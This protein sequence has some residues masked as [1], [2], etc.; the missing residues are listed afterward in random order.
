MQQQTAASTKNIKNKR[1]TKKP[2]QI[3]KNKVKAINLCHVNAVLF[4]YQSLIRSETILPFK[5]PFCLMCQAPTNGVPTFSFMFSDFCSYN[6]KVS[7]FPLQPITED[8]PDD[9]DFDKAVQEAL[10]ETKR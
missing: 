2:Y 10:I 9:S 5:L 7:L 4:I 6:N 8:L 3:K 1:K